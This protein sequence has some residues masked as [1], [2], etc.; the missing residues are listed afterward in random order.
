[1]KRSFLLSVFV[2]ALIAFFGY[3]RCAAP[4]ATIVFYGLVQDEQGRALPDVVVNWSVMRAGAFYPSMG[5]SM[6][7]QRNITHGQYR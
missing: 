3:Q 6:G 4:S 7:P 5:L 2:L 1:M